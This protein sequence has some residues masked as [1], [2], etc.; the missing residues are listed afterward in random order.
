M[1][2]IQGVD[3]LFGNMLSALDALDLRDTTDLFV[4]SDYGFVTHEE[5]INLSHV[6]VDAGLKRAQDST[7]VICIDT[8]IYVQEHDA[9]KIRQ[10]AMF[11]Q[12]Q[13][14]C[15]PIFTHHQPEGN[16]NLGR[17][18]GTLSMRRIGNDHARAGDILY[19]YN[20]S[21]KANRWGIRGMASG[22]SGAR[23][24]SIS[25]FELHSMLFA[26]GPDFKSDLTSRVPSGNIDVVLTTLH[27]FGIQPSDQ[28][29]GRVLSEALLEGPDPEEVYFRK[30]HIR[31]QSGKG[32]DRFEEVIQISHV[33]DTWYVD[34]GGV[35]REM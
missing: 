4:M 5:P 29:D 33:G 17:V 26:A 6:L 15:G 25:P 34:K 14:W 28:H 11:L 18:E 32:T 35:R 2:A 8:Q 12:Q 27:L 30:E 24:G 22:G 1:E 7:D 9:E 3:A 13:V 16:Q 23:H 20:W 21:A 10:I 31:A 19:A